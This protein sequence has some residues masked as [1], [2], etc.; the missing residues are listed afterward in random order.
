[1]VLFGAGVLAWFGW[2]RPWWE[3]YRVMVAEVVGVGRLV[4]WWA[5][6][7][8]VAGLGWWMVRSWW[9]ARSGAGGVVGG[10]DPLGRVAF[11]V[12]PV[13]GGGRRRRPGLGQG[14]RRV[15]ELEL[16]PVLL[17]QADGLVASGR[18][19]RVL[20]G[21]DSGR[22]VWGVSV[23][24]ELGASAQ[25]AV[26]VVW[27]FARVED[28]PLEGGVEVSDRVPVDE[29]GGGTVVRCYLV[30]EDLS[31]GLN[32]PLAAPDHPMARVW[33]VLSAHPE[34]DV[35]LRVDLVPLS[36][37]ERERAC[38]ARLQG[39][40]DDDPDRD[41]W[42]TD[43]N[44]DRLA[45][46]RV[47]LR[48]A[49]AGAGHAA[50][51]ESVAGRVC[52]VL[53]MFWR[54]DYNRLVVRDVPDG[55][56]DQ[57][58]DRGVIERELPVWHWDS[59]HTLLGLPPEKIAGVSG[60]RLPDP[61]VLETFDPR[62]PGRLMPIGVVSEKGRERLVGIPWGGD[63]D[64]SVDWTVGATGSGK[65][66]HATSR[67]IAVAEAGRGFLYLDPHRNAVVDIKRYLAA[68]H[69]DRI[70]E[71]DL[72]AVDVRGEPVSAGWN[73]LDLTVVPAQMRKARIDNLKDM[74]P[75]ALFPDYVGS[76]AKAPQTATIIRKTVECLL[77]L[78][79]HLPPQLQANIFCMENLLLDEEW[80][81]LA[82]A[83]LPDRD[84]KWWHHTYPMIVGDKGPLSAALKPALN[85]LEQ[86]KTKDRVQALLG[87]SQ[88]TVRWRD[89]IDGGKILL[90]VLNNDGSETDNLLARLMVGEMVTAFKE[91]SLTHQNGEPVRPFHL[92]LD[93]FQSY[94]SV[95]EAHAAVFVQE[96]RKYG[97]KVHVINQS[98][99]ALSPKTREM[100]LAN[101]THLFAG[102]VGSPADAKNLAEAMGGQ[103]PT[104]QHGDDHHGPAPVEGRD[105]LG[106]P[107]WHFTCQITLNGK[108][109]PAFQL[110]GIDANKTWA[111]LRSD[112][113]ITQQITENT[114]LEP[115]DKRLDH[116]DTLPERIVQWL[117][118]GKPFTTTPPLS[119][120]GANGN[121]S[122]ARTPQPTN[123]DTPPVDTR[124]AWAKDRIIQDPDAIT[125]TAWFAASYTQWCQTKNIQPLPDTQLQQ[126]L[127]RH[128]GPSQTVRIK[129][130]VTRARKGIKLQTPADVTGV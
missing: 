129:G 44:V 20:W 119:H 92:F 98:P 17:R 103:Q 25:R 112:Q 21:R 8:F 85:A 125:P 86:W 27:P 113:Q 40:G 101:L 83:R 35:E 94:A 80:R 95:L 71:I 123:G 68:R 33:D 96:L 43:A 22:L 2:V 4:L 26:S 28:W 77:H 50:E 81:N 124:H 9:R 1:M 115:V 59:V 11:S 114:G 72:Q 13:R 31:R 36:P 10:W 61:P 37:G 47:L 32:T 105:L 120:L 57:I 116:Y 82:V 63:T 91:R 88:S 90:V 34:V 106:M 75:A 15:P 16:W 109:S 89:I 118:T 56:F 18:V 48:V 5:S 130:K 58:W 7:A 87:A 122:P 110:K 73:P 64:A 67:V 69:A 126:Y 108:P 54:T 93:E 6:V 78:N 53:D 79:Y 52:R 102:R 111:H 66:W 45:G 29:E 100:L 70:L 97:A 76:S 38:S 127:T 62:A 65:T 3:E 30:P 49:R 84:Q 117:H 39:L 51:C 41:L 24:K 23:D 12:V 107:R 14:S 19:V 104:G 60:R 42:E 121:S 128:H 74:L 55:L 99:S 46:V